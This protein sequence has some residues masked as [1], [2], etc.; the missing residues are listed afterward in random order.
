M[1][2]RV[3]IHTPNFIKSLEDN[4][5]LYGETLERVRETLERALDKLN[6]PFIGEFGIDLY[7]STRGER[8]IRW[9]LETDDYGNSDIRRVIG[10]NFEL[11]AANAIGDCTGWVERSAGSFLYGIPD[12]LNYQSAVFYTKEGVLILTILSASDK[13][14]NWQIMHTVDQ[15]F[16][17]NLLES[18]SLYSLKND[19]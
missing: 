5:P 14:P 2:T 7:D 9:D 11:V 18:R 15:F 16:S 13:E 19:R 3:E 8:I 10:E 4:H 12:F 17:E 1:K 6:Q